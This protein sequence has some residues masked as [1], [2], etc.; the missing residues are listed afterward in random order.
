MYKVVT[1]LWFS[2]LSFQLRSLLCLISG[3]HQLSC[4]LQASCHT[5]Q[6]AFA[7]NGSKQHRDVII[8]LQLIIP[9][10]TQVNSFYNCNVSSPSEVLPWGLLCFFSSSHWLRLSC[11]PPLKIMTNITPWYAS[12]KIY[13]LLL[14]GGFAW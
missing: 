12:L 2:S 7:V 13:V 5:K 4:P 14:G 11:L 9:W 1:F 10:E 6:I 8:S 3:T